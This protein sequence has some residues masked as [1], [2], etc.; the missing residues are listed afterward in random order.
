MEP[1]C[2]Q[3][4]N[5]NGDT[6]AGEIAAA[7]PGSRL[8]FLT[9][10]AGVLDGDGRLVQRLTRLRAD[11]LRRAGV[12]TGGMLPKIEAGFRAAGAGSSAIIVDGRAIGAL[13]A[14]MGPSPIGTAFAYAV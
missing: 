7:L 2:G 14:A 12:L 5:V 1:G 3:L 8:V 9:D 13:A 6:V 11:E 10:V 4:L